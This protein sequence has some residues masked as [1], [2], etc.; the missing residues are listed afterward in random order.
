MSKCK[1]LYC[2]LSADSDLLT[3]S[4]IFFPSSAHSLICW[5]ACA[6]FI[7]WQAPVHW[8]I[9]G[10]AQREAINGHVT[11]IFHTRPLAD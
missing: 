8:Y 5:R 7:S 4:Q 10:L 11:E 9:T 1:S 6:L 2:C 3:S